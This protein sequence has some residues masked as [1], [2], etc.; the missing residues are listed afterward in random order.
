MHISWN[1]LNK[2][3][4]TI[5]AI[6]AYH[7]MEFIIHNTDDELARVQAKMEGVGSPNNDGLPHDNGVVGTWIR[8]EDLHGIYADYV[9]AVEFDDIKEA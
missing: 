6:E 1:F 5:D 2:R 8:P 9:D 7:N 3:K 4:A